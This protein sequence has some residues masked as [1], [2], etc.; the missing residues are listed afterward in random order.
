MNKVF[1][2]QKRNHG[3]AQGAVEFALVLPL[4]LLIMLGLIETGRLIFHYSAVTNAAREAMRYGSAT[5]LSD[6]G[7]TPRFMDCAGIV[8]AAVRVGFLGSVQPGDVTITYFSADGTNLGGCPPPDNAIQTGARIQ[9]EVNSLFDT[10]IPGLLPYQG[11]TLSSESSRTIIRS[12]AIQGVDSPGGGGGGGGSGP[13]STPTP[14]WDPALPTYTPTNT[15]TNT[16]TPTS[17]PSPT[18]GPSP[19]PTNTL[20]PYLAWISPSDSNEDGQVTTICSWPHTDFAVRAYDP[21]LCTLSPEECDG[22]GIAN[23]RFELRQDNDSGDVL[24]SGTIANAPFCLFGA[25]EDNPVACNW[26]PEQEW[27]SD[28]N[29]YHLSAWANLSYGGPELALS[30]HILNKPVMGAFVDIVRPGTDNVVISRNQSNLEALVYQ[31]FDSPSCEN[32]SDAEKRAINGLHLTGKVRIRLDEKQQQTYVSVQAF[33]KDIDVDTPPF[34]LGGET[35]GKCDVL[36]ITKWNLLKPNQTYRFQVS[37]GIGDSTKTQSREFT[38][39]PLY[40]KIVSPAS[41]Q[42]ITRQ[43]QASFQVIA[44]DGRVCN[45][46]DSCNGV[47]INRVEM[48]VLRPDGT[49]IHSNLSLVTDTTAPYCH[50]NLLGSCAPLANNVQWNNLPNGSYILRARACPQAGQEGLCTAWVDA[51]FSVQKQYNI[52]FTQ[53]TDDAQVITNRSQTNFGASFSGTFPATGRLVIANATT[54]Q[55]I[56]T[57]SNQT[58]SLYCFRVTGNTCDVFQ[59]NSTEWNNLINGNYLLLVQMQVGGNWETL[60]VT[61]FRVNR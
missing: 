58:S 23:I 33:D 40:I 29:L 8:D 45:T 20:T 37:F 28:I 54:G 12:V 57:S 42:V 25:S 9:V 17:T 22:Q 52:T 46:G 56:I 24:S 43:A 61:S 6:D 1:L 49:A 39:P 53:P 14:T 47:G 55:A 60:A 19:T 7:I 30:S 27:L 50:N 11:M 26:M 34:C 35:D 51:P 5:G 21:N 36:D 48:R 16:A 3:K 41:G 32:L 2:F 18:D 38:T 10:I 4:L 15:P 13:T 31:Y 59:N 44:Y